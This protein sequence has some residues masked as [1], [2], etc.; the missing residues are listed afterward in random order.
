M[1]R[2]KRIIG[3]VSSSGVENQKKVNKKR[4]S[5]PLEVTHYKIYP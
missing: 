5:T 2:I 4:F 3:F 1:I